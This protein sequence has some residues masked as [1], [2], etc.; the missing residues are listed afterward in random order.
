MTGF[1]DW[2]CHGLWGMDDGAQ[3]FEQSC[4]MVAL[5]VREGI[6][7]MAMTPHAYPG[8]EPFNLSRYKRHL[9]RL[10]QWVEAENIPVTLLEGAEIHYSP[11]VLPM[12][13]EGRVP[14]LNRS[15]YVLIELSPEA[16]FQELEKGVLTLFRSGYIPV[17]AHVE[18]YPR[19]YHQARRLI[20]LREE[21]DVCYQVN[22]HTVVQK[23]S[24]PRALFLKQLFDA[25]AVDLMATDAHDSRYRPPNM[26][27]AYDRL[28][29]RY[30]R[31]YAQRLTNFSPECH[32]QE[33]CKR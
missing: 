15:R 23:Q 22:A 19:L 11:E 1:S 13:R 26:Q 21:M 25:H 5:A 24:L 9:N 27:L 20:S 33:L 31:E 4:R 6:D 29:Q 7:T 32:L 30:G 3:S 28:E 2:H 14:A 10:Q 8:R 12:L 18:R 17:I 16:D